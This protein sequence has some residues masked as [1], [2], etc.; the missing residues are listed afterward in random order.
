M[1]MIRQC[2]NCGR[3]FSINISK[4]RLARG[5]GAFCSKVCVRQWKDN[6]IPDMNDDLAYMIGVILGDGYTINKRYPY[7]NV[8]RI[9]LTTKDKEFALAFKTAQQN[10]GLKSRLNQLKNGRNKQLYVVDANNR[11]LTKWICNLDECKIENLMVE[12]ALAV[13]FIKGFYD[14]E[15]DFARL[16]LQIRISNTNLS[17]LKLVNKLLERFLN[18]K[19]HVILQKPSKM[20]YG[21]KDVYR[22]GIYKQ[23]DTLKFLQTV[24]S[25]IPRK[26]IPNIDQICL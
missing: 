9:G 2:K 14:S 20:H 17:K 25:N 7:L 4:K 22:L 24:G 15:G 11:G 23:A 21:K 16:R 1:T 8:Y 19:G 3:I 10:L 18:I 26:T 13:A 12:K 5:W 6:Q